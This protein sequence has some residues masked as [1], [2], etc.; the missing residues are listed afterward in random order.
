MFLQEANRRGH[1]GAEERERQVG[2]RRDDE[3]GGDHASAGQ[4]LH[5]AHD[6]ALRGRE[7]HAGDGNGTCRATQQVPVHKEVSPTR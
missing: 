4:P 5:R 3:G 6:R 2:E 1:Q 7:P